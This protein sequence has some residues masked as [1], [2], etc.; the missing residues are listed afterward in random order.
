MVDGTNDPQCQQRATPETEASTSQM[1]FA[2]QDS[3]TR[4][5]RKLVLR[6]D[7]NQEG[8][9]NEVGDALPDGLFWL[10][11]ENWKWEKKHGG[12]RYLL[13]AGA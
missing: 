9:I 1:F 7:G 8:Q 4:S 6:N 13:W 12:T 11:P 2:S 3:I 10:E 5:L